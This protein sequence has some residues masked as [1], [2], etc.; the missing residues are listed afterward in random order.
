MTDAQLHDELLT[1]FLA[2]HETT[3]NALTWT[4]YLLAQ[5]PDAEARLHAELDAV[6]GPPGAGRAPVPDDVPALP[7]TRQVLAES[8]RLFPP[9]W[10]IGRRATEAFEI[11]GYA[12]PARTVVLTS[13]WVVHRDPRWFAD[14]LR[15]D[16]ARWAPEAAAARHRFSYF[17][18]GAGTRVCIGEQF[19][20]TEGVLV[21]AAV[22]RRWRLRLAAGELERVRPEPIV[23]LRPRGGVRM[24]VE[25]R[26]A[27][28]EAPA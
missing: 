22:A 9:A 28:D 13:Q 20:W 6:L 11:G 19:A 10:V 24:R 18:F 26:G 4:F 7:Y 27:G 15:F 17:P 21:L 12:V 3:S 23:T 5:H 1:L 2:G 25:A 8:M 16:P 14:P